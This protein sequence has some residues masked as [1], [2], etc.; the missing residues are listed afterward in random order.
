MKRLC[1]AVLDKTGMTWAFHNI[2]QYTSVDVFIS[3]LR[4]IIVVPRR[5][6]YRYI[7]DCNLYIQLQVFHNLH[8]FL[9]FTQTLAHLTAEQLPIEK[10]GIALR[11]VT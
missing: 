10:T 1:F 4:A 3:M 8:I 6:N 7:I 11:C 9:G 2:G 5:A